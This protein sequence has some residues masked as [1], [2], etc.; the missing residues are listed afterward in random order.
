MS[1]TPEEERE[2]LVKKMEQ[3]KQDIE[4]FKMSGNADK[5]IETMF[6]YEEFL[7]RELK[8][9]EAKLNVNRS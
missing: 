8:E 6:M 3:V 4:I 2:H 1:M 7:Q 9:I 5:K